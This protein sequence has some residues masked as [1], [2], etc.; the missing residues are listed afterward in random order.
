MGF[1]VRSFHPERPPALLLGGLNLVRAAGLGG[2]P[3]IVASPQPD[4]PAFASRFTRGSLLLPPL[5]RREAVVQA[6]LAAGAQL[7]GALGR[8]IPLFYA[9]DDY[10]SLI[11][12]NY[13]ALSEHFTLIVN[14][15]DVARALVDKQR[16]ESFCRDRDLPLPRTLSWEELERWHGP[17]L[18]K[19][20]VKTGYANSPVFLRL[21]GGAGKARV[22][23][24]GPE[25][26]ATPLAWQ[27]REDL[28]V[29]EYVR[30]DDRNLWSFHGYADE[31][32]G[33]LASFVGRKIRTWPPITGESS[34]IELAHDDA[35]AL[36]GR[37]IAARATLRGVF[38]IDFK[39]DAVSGAWRV[40]EI[41]ARFNLW[42]YLG[43]CNGINL[44]RIAY[45]YLVYGARPAATPYRTTH[46]WLSLRNDFRAFRRL[47]A[48]G[49]LDLGGWLRS[50]VEAPKVY[51]FFS[52]TD[53]KPF[54]QHWRK[55]IRS[56]LKRR[57]HRWLATAS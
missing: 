2:I 9:T 31:D 49:E 53:P 26:I 45:D 19:P 39:R 17:V 44:P 7:A 36:V 51:D 30:G 46:R 23:S 11:V 14:Q 5:E 52:W 13:A 28:L 47:A 27:L 56:A 16:F 40:L 54:V 43:A 12:D 33:L 57:M 21:F 1:D 10:L 20:K 37:Q 18:V 4:W 8:R 6:V 55:R 3:A 48:H 22:F 32:G 41:N 50:L 25:L 34:F 42:H 29:Q 24:S 15:R 35:F 38:K